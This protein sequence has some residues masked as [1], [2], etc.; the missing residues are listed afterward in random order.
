MTNL[1]MLHCS[2]PGLSSRSLGLLFNYLVCFKL[3]P[4]LPY[5][6]KAHC[7]CQAVVSTNRYTLSTTVV[8]TAFRLDLIP[9]VLQRCSDRSIEVHVLDFLLNGMDSEGSRSELS[10]W[11]PEFFDRDIS[12]IQWISFSSLTKLP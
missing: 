9:Q 5:L 12:Y 3:F 11:I 6:V 4:L 2:C 7:F 8:C 10:E 1:H